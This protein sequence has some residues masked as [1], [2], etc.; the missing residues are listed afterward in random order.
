MIG[1]RDL[2]RVVKEEAFFVKVF[3]LSEEVVSF[4]LELLPSLVELLS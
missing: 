4:P 3:D 2:A 1:L